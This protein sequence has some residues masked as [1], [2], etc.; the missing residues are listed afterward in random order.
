VDSSSWVI[1]MSKELYVENDFVLNENG[2]K[3]IVLSG[4]EI[5]IVVCHPI[6][7]ELG[8][9]TTTRS[10]EMAQYGAVEVVEAP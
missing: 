6:T 2:Q 5:I 9:I 1:V 10:L 8:L 4:A 3:S 7:S